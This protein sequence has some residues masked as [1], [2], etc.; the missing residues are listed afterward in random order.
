[1]KV[2]YVMLNLINY[3]FSLAGFSQRE[4]NSNDKFNVITVSNGDYLKVFPCYLPIQAYCHFSSHSYSQFGEVQGGAVV[5]SVALRLDSSEFKLAGWLG[6]LLVELRC[7][8]SACMW[9]QFLVCC[10]LLQLE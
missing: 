3:F 7:P 4:Q 1:M 10:F 9:I 6:L 5:S 2:L 8:P